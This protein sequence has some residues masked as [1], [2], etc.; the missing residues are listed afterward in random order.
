MFSILEEAFLHKSLSDS[1]TEMLPWEHSWWSGAQQTNPTSHILY[2]LTAGSSGKESQSCRIKLRFFFAL[3]V[4]QFSPLFSLS[5]NGARP[6]LLGLPISVVSKPQPAF[7][8][9]ERFCTSPNPWGTG[10]AQWVRD[11]NHLNLQP[12]G[13]LMSLDIPKHTQDCHQIKSRKHQGSCPSAEGCGSNP[14]CSS[15]MSWELPRAA[16]RNHNSVFHWILESLA[17]SSSAS[18]QLGWSKKG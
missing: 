12:Q 13:S 4:G 8:P 2:L 17:A 5:L 15:G 7:S 11:C 14:G 6:H 18:W 10:T 9:S 16:E 3:A 1:N